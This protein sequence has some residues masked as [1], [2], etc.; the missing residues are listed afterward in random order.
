L[1]GFCRIILL[2][3]VPLIAVVISLDQKFKQ[4]MILSESGIECFLEESKRV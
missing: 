3:E 2:I 1:S 4:E